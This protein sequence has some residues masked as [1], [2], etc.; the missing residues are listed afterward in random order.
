MNKEYPSKEQVEICRK[1]GDLC[2]ID[3]PK[4]IDLF[5]YNLLMEHFSWKVGYIKLVDLLTV[6]L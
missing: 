4:D 5:H 2:G 1:L 3:V 6:E